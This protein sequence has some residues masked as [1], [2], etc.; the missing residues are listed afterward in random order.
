MSASAPGPEYSDWL[1]KQEAADAIG[2][3][4]KTIEKFSAEGKLQSAKRSQP[5]RPPAAVYHPGDVEALRKE[6]NPDAQP[7][8][9]PR[10]S[11]ALQTTSPT[12]S[13]TSQIVVASAV[14]DALGLAARAM[15]DA[16]GKPE[17]PRLFL[18]LDQAAE[19][20]G[21]PRSY[22]RELMREEKLPAI[23]TGRGWRIR[24]RD[25]EAL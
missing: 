7:F 15:T 14:L 17:P 3:S 25:L 1:T 23:K 6:R 4:T 10:E 21:L 2:V 16:V 8:V 20:S 18:T 12:A 13:P 24:R 22:L 11:Q 5:G 19:F 9:L